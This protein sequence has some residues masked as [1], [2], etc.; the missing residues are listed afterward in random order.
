M[1][2][3]ARATAVRAAGQPSIYPHQ[4]L[5]ALQAVQIEHTR[6]LPGLAGGG[7]G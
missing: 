4:Y 7:I 6:V 2:E 5:K 3:P 1:R